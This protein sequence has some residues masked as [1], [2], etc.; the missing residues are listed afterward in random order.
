MNKKEG[1]SSGVFAGQRS[2]L[3]IVGG[4]TDVEKSSGRGCVEWLAEVEI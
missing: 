1:S 3:K 4:R 2:R